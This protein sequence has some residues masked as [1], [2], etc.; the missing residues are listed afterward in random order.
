MDWTQILLSIAIPLVVSVI[1]WTLTYIIPYIS[2]NWISNRI[3]TF[4]K[5]DPKEHI[6]IGL[7]INQFSKYDDWKRLTAIKRLKRMFFKKVREIEDDNE[8][9]WSELRASVINMPLENVLNKLNLILSVLKNK[10]YEK[11]HNIKLSSEDVR[12]N[13]E[14]KIKSL[15]EYQNNYSKLL[16]K[17]PKAIIWDICFTPSKYIQNYNK[18]E[19]A[20]T[21]NDIEI[22]NLK[23]NYFDEDGSL[24]ADEFLQIKGHETPKR[25]NNEEIITTFNDVIL[26]IDYP[27]SKFK[28]SELTYRLSLGLSDHE[29][30]NETLNRLIYEVK[31]EIQMNDYNKWKK[32]FNLR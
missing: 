5:N 16:K 29:K 31:E 32:Q 12:E 18:E 20:L 19:Y 17:Y 3:I 2:P 1:V 30:S 25:Q 10:N 15:E 4:T 11:D 14:K 9:K 26:Y 24:S 13:F 27:H 7:I 28:K 8:S 22:M 6:E 23:D 21:I